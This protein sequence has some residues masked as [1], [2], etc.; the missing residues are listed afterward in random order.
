[1]IQVYKK[2]LVLLCCLLL[3][4]GV[5]RT[6]A[7]SDEHPGAL[8]DTVLTHSSDGVFSSTAS[9]TFQLKSSFKVTEKGKA[10]I[11]VTT[12]AGKKVRSDSVSVNIGGGDSKD[13][14][15]NVS[16][17]KPGFYKINFMVDVPDYNDT[18]RKAF[19]IRPDQISS[20]Y[21]KPA[22]F[23]SF[24]HNARLELDKVAPEYKLTELP[25]SAKGTHRFSRL[26]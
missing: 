25:D 26:K 9:F 24:W 5:Q 13:Y 11:L 23:E 1:M 18:V 17:L 2:S 16:G 14:E 10:S 6:L 4:C 15:F 20:Q 8:V 22:D 19:G 12:E 3:V 7:Q 21:G